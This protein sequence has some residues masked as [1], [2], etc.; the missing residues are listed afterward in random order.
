MSQSTF[1]RERDPERNLL[2]SRVREGNDQSNCLSAVVD[3][4]IAITGA[5]R[6][7]LQLVDARSGALTIAAQRGFSD[8]FLSYFARVPQSAPV[9]AAAA[10]RAKQRIVVE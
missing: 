9:T 8:S 10:M 3:T 7:S 2:R 1:E 6:G 5:P 4:A